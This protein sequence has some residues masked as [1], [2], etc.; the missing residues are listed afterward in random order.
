M[1]K[2]EAMKKPAKTL[3]M[4]CVVFNCSDS[5]TVSQS[6]TFFRGLARPG[7]CSRFD[8][9]NPIDVEVPSVVAR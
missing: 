1:G 9:F 3:A 8:H 7:A 2:M 6:P 5:I 4:F